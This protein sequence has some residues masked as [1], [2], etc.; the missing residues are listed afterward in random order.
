VGGYHGGNGN[1]AVAVAIGDMKIS[2]LNRVQLFVAG[3]LAAYQV[4]VG[5]EGFA[6]IPILAY[7][8]AFGVLLVAALLLVIL[9]FDALDFPIVAVVSTLIPLGLSL[10]L[11]WQGFPNLQIVYSIFV[12]VGFLAILVTRIVPIHNKTPTIVLAVVHGVAGMVIF[13]LPIIFAIQGKAKPLFS[14]VGIGGALIGIGGLGLSLL[15]S[16]N[17]I[18]PKETILNAIPTLLLLT[19]L[20]FVVGFM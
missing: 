17:P 4:A 20:C 6:A 1:D 16:G 14:L 5:I 8:V 15:K 11:V 12:V 2:H 9:G 10:G 7:T 13:L 18:L 3:I 19:T